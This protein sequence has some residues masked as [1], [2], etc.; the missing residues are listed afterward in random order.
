MSFSVGLLL[1][2]LPTTEKHLPSFYNAPTGPHYNAPTTGC[3]APP[4]RDNQLSHSSHLFPHKMMMMAVVMVMVML[5]L[6]VK[7]FLD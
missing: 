2:V 5:M 6:M 4:C 3:S 1:R 7:F